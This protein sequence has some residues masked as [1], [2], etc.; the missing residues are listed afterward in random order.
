[1]NKRFLAG[2]LAVLLFSALGVLPGQG[3]TIWRSMP[4][5][6]MSSIMGSEGMFVYAIALAVP[7]DGSEKTA[8]PGS[9]LIRCEGDLPALP[10]FAFEILENSESHVLQMPCEADNAFCSERAIPFRV[11]WTTGDG[12]DHIRADTA[13]IRNEAFLHPRN[14]AQRDRWLH[15]LDTGAELGIGFD[16]HQ[17]GLFEWT[18]DLRQ[19]ASKRE[20]ICS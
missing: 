15:W 17:D 9:I 14:E 4:A 6:M 13:G 18:W 8:T 5:Q 20:Q 10:V 3:Q 19:Y 1:M 2:L 11:S 7:T 16:W 12:K